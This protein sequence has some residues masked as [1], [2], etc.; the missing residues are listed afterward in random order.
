MINNNN[1]V[2]NDKKNVKD[3]HMAVNADS[4]IRTKEGLSWIWTDVQQWAA[5]HRENETGQ[6]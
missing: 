5:G 6:C 2:P 1:S 4:M 3:P